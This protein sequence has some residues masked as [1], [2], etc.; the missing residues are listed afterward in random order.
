M[1]LYIHGIFHCLKKDCRQVQ[2]WCSFFC[3][4]KLQTPCA[5]IDKTLS[6]VNMFSS[7]TCRVRHRMPF[8]T[9][10]IN[11]VYSFPL[12]CGANGRCLNMRLREHHSSLKGPPFSHLNTQCAACGCT[13]EFRR[14]TIVFRH[15]ESRIKEIAEAYAISKNGD[16]CFSAPSTALLDCKLAYL[17]K[18]WWCYM[19]SL[20]DVHRLRTHVSFFFLC[21]AFHFAWIKKS[22]VSQCS[23]CPDF[24]CDSSLCYSTMKPRRATF[25]EKKGIYWNKTLF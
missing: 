18:T 14:T 6:S 4:N 2:R 21:F 5:R 23:C 13:P 20:F 22:V 7:S 3:Q 25:V 10:K 1:I 16:A 17:D 15:T 8:V 24:F 9:C 12:S 11:V 19:C